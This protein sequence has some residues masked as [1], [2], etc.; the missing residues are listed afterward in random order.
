MADEAAAEVKEVMEGKGA[1][2]W[3]GIDDTQSTLQ[4][5]ATEGDLP[6]P[7]Y[8]LVDVDGIVVSSG[9]PDEEK[10]E[11]LLKR[12]FE[13]ALGRDLHGQLAEAVADYERGT[14]GAAWLAAGTLVDDEDAQVAE[15]AA[16]LRAKVER[17]VSWQRD[18]IEG[19]LAKGKRAEAMGGLLVFETRFAKM[20]VATWATD[21]I[22][23]L[24]KHE[25][26]HADRF[27]WAKL[28]KAIAKEAKGVKTRGARNSVI[29]AYKK[30][31]KSHKGTV[32][33]RIAAERMKALGG[34]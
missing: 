26:V 34:K 20:D 4:R 31:V 23:D 10:I 9:L 5:Y 11:E 12:V 33:A 1:R 8:Y 22:K 30:V 25:D 2:Y 18:R 17:Y 24:E 16:F 21:Q 29:Y 15:D 7:Q 3:I 19:A 6:I 13:P 32:A 27:A 14:A 28:R